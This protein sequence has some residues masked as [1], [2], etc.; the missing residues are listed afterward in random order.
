MIDNFRQDLSYALRGLRAKPAFT[1]AVV[2]TL[3]LGIGANAAMFS[4]VDRLL[5][6]P[7]ALL[8][9]PDRVHR[10][11]G[12]SIFRGKER[13]GL[14]GQYARF[15]DMTKWTRSFDLTAGFTSRDLAVGVGDA[16]R[17]MP[18]AIVSATF[19]QF[20]DA[21]PALGRYFGP[22]EDTPPSGAPVAVASYARWQTQYGGRRE[23]L[24]S[25]IQIGSVLYTIV[26]VAPADFVGLWSNQ[27]PA[28]FIPITSYG[29][30]MAQRL[31]GPLSKESWWTTYHWGWMEMMARRK[32]GVS[33]TGANA[34]LTQAYVRSYEAERVGSPRSPPLSVAKPR[35]FVGSI[36]AERGPRASGFAKVATWLGGV[37][38]VVLLIACAN[39]ANLL[40]ARALRRRREIAVRLALG[41]SRS[42]L[43]SQL[44]TE[45]VLLAVGGGIAGILVAQWS[46]IGLRAAF[47]P[48]TADLTVVR[49]G[50]TVLFAGVAALV[51]GLLTGLAPV[52]QASRASLTSDLKAGAREG[53]FQ[54][55]RLRTTLLV[56]Q[57][58]LSVLLLVGAGLFVRSLG[59]VRNIRLGY[60]VDPVLIA[61][62]N[63]RGVQL[64]SAHEVQLRQ[65]LLQTALAT[66]GVENASFQTGIPFWS[67]WSVGLF[68][69][70]I[71]T[72]ARLGR[73]DVNAVSP[74]YFATMGTRI[75]RGR[76]IQA[77]DLGNAPL[78][79]VVSQAMANT[80]WPGADAIGKCVRMNADTMPCRTVVGIA[81]DIKSHQLSNETDMYY[82]VPAT[83]FNPNSTG[84]FIR[85]HGDAARQAEAVRR[86]LQRE[87]PGASYIV[88]NALS[89]VI[90]DQT[91]SFRLGASMFS[92]FGILALVLAAIGLYSV[93]AYNVAQRTHELGVRVALGAQRADVLRLVIS[94]GFQLG[95]AGVV[96]GGAIALGA[97]RW[98][99]PLLFDQSPRDPLVFTVVALVLIGVSILASWIPARRAAQ[100]EPTQALRYE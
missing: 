25:T 63:M 52:L 20:F 94:E 91:K 39:V 87:M 68:V 85:V 35:A 12:A 97:G 96:I 41:V 78:V 10:I 56:M 23:I 88:T 57:G 62:L 46:S 37:A 64:D 33:E 19:F 24:G 9:S 59:H 61:D 99:T 42:R 69:S 26:G 30:A 45:S 84:L 86:S 17:E 27:P 13:I 90:G 100:V 49:D 54:R 31:N 79:I 82:Y 72:V 83:Q 48:K 18:I 70:G 32:P 22:A 29:G 43:L 6:R 36:L 55:S 67:T 2:L 44:L 14:G 73:F 40:F 1:T 98:I 4:L 15:V 7:P 95:I 74:G 8:K 92:A 11:Y 21:P 5:F 89:E 3:A 58:A 53:S 51:T 28:Y 47:L 60:D 38:L 16:S 76:G 93:I 65:R 71:D 66:P 81:E 75:L 34:D 80:L 77:T 50:R